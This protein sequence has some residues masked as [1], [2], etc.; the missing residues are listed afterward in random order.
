[1]PLSRIGRFTF[2]LFFAIG[3]IRHEQPHLEVNIDQTQL[4]EGDLIFRLGRGTSSQIVNLADKN[5]SYSHIG[6]LVK[7]SL[8]EYC[9]I[10]AVPGESGESGGKEVVKCDPLLRFLDSDRT[11]K[12]VVMRVDSIEKI[13]HQVIGKAKDYYQRGLFFV[14]NY[15]LS[16]TSVLYCT[17]LIY[18]VFLSAGIDLSED[19]RHSF[20]LLKEEIIF[21]SDILKNKRLYEICRVE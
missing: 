6:L 1:M 21:P 5:H 2:V 18:R 17:E 4:Q 15:A 3:C 20:P 7:D 9:V 8:G 10:H 14:H 16:D 12:G 19:R 11:V 13:S